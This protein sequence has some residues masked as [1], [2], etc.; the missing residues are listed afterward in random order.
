MKEIV[1]Q[2]KQQHPAR[3]KIVVYCPTI[4]QVKQLATVLGGTAFYSS[5]GS[6]AE[7]ARIVEMLKGGSERVFTSTNTL[8]E[9][10]DAPYVRVVIHAGA[11]KELDDY[12]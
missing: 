7:K 11:P 3:D 4:E 2:K 5:I 8:G 1:E 9:G 12:S 6:E 10:I